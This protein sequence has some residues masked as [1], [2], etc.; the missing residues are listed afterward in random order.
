MNKLLKLLFTMTIIGTTVSE[1]H[2]VET[3]EGGIH[4]KTFNASY[5]PEFIDPLVNKVGERIN[6]ARGAVCSKF[7]ING[8]VKDTSGALLV[9]TFYAA[10]TVANDKDG[11][12]QTA[13]GVYMNSAKMDQSATGW[14]MFSGEYQRYAGIA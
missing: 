14:K 3:D 5:E 7:S 4:V 8:E 1:Q 2:G 9:A 12:G 6:E 10:A 13:G 11:F